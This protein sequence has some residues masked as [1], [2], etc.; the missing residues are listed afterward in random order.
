M[1]NKK[2]FYTQNY[3]KRKKKK[4]EHNE[5]RVNIHGLEDFQSALYSCQRID[6]AVPQRSSSKHLQHSCLG[7]SVYVEL[8]RT[9]LSF[10]WQC[11]GE[12]Q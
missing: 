10:T 7:A 11:E 8:E 4:V 5:G 9:N 12:M 2:V 1:L 6:G 3:K